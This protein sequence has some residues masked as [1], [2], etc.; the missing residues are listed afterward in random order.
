MAAGSNAPVA[1]KDAM[2]GSDARA[3]LHFRNQAHNLLG[4]AM[5]SR[6]NDMQHFHYCHQPSIHSGLDI[7]ALSLNAP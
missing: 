2:T 1:A 5:P 7:A 6:W 4:P 3:F